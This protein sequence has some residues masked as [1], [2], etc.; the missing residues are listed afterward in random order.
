[1]FNQA[2]ARP[3]VNDVFVVWDVVAS[4]QHHVHVLSLCRSTKLFFSQVPK[5]FTAF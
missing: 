2:A 3:D 5:I 4:P 1:M